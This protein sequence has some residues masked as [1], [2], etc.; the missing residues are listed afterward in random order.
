M[1]AV[2][3]VVWISMRISAATETQHPTA[4]VVLTLCMTEVIQTQYLIAAVLTKYVTEVIQSYSSCVT[5][6]MTEVIQTQY[7]IAVA[8]PST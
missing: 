7:L 1:H 4:A 5:Q 2:C 6:Y 8:L 3:I